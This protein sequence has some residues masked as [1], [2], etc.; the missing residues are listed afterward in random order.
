VVDVA[1]HRG[2]ETLDGAPRLWESSLMIAHYLKIYVFSLVGFLVIDMI[3][4][5]VVARGFYR[6]HLGFLL[7]DQ[8]NWWAA[9]AFYLLF[10]AGVLVFAVAPGLQAQSL[11]RTLLLGGFFGLVTYATYDLTNMATVKSWPWVVTVV[12]MVWGTVLAAAVSAI[13]YLV[14]AGQS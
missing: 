5:G 3:W 12:D 1:G 6:R 7:A 14:G 9:I 11:A 2:G 13:G 8:V 4:L 10:V